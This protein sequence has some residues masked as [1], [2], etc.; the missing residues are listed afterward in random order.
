MKKRKAAT[1]SKK[2]LLVNVTI[3]NACR[4]TLHKVKPPKYV[5][6]VNVDKFAVTEIERHNNCVSSQEVFSSA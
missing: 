1:T 5:V 2:A 4:P 3:S 6:V